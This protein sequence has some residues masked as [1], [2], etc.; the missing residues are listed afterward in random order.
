MA[1]MT[2]KQAFYSDVIIT[3]V[4]GGIGYWSYVRGYVH[5]HDEDFND[6]NRTPAHTEVFDF[7]DGDVE[8]PDAKWHKL[9]NKV[10]AKAFK[11]IMSKDEIPYAS[12]EWRKRMVAAYWANDC[13]DIDSGDADMVVQIALLGE[14]V[15]G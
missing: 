1:K 14:V 3:A 13:C 2:D 9:D 6:E 10:I 15:Y 5:G 4:E 8:A 12:K 7:E 11:L